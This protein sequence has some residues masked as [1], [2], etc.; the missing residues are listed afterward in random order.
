VNGNSVP[1]LLAYAIASQ[2]WV[3]MFEQQNSINK[4]VIGRLRLWIDGSK[5]TH[6]GHIP[7]GFGKMRLESE[8]NAISQEQRPCNLM[9]SLSYKSFSPVGVFIYERAITNPES[10]NSLVDLALRKWLSRI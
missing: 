7:E 1:P 6:V 2:V 8:W 9:H 3:H 4:E 10:L 5:V